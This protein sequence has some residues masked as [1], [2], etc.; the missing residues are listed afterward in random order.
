MLGVHIAFLTHA[1]V[2]NLKRDVFSFAEALF[3]NL[4]VGG[5][6]L[7]L[8]LKLGNLKTLAG[9]SGLE[10]LVLSCQVCDLF[11]GPC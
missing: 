1:L 4:S 7:E 9:T 8:L 3:E 5:L 2:L 11:V 10:G 6:L